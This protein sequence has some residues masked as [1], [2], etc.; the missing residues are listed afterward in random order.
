[1]VATLHQQRAIEARR[2]L[3]RYRDLLEEQHD[4]LLLNE[5]ISVCSDSEEELW[6]NADQPDACEHGAS[7]P[8]LARA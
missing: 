3:Q 2:V 5:I 1:M 4:T 7:H 8:S 6:K